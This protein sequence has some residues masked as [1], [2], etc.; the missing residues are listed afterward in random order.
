MRKL[1]D[2]PLGIRYL[3][4]SIGSLIASRLSSLENRLFPVE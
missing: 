2:M 4:T 1:I 3:P